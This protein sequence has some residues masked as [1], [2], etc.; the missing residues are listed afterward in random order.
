MKILVIGDF[1]GTFPAKLKKQI[2]KEKVDFIVG[3]GDYAGVE[4]WT[5]YILYIFNLK[6]L[7]DRESAEKFYGKKKY[8][9]LMKK[10]FKQGEKVLKELNSLGKGFY[11]FGNGDD[12]WYNYPFDRRI[13]QAK[14][15]RVRFLKK[16]KNIKEMT[17]KVKNYNK[18][19]FLGFGGYMDASANYNTR[20]GKKTKDSI[21]RYDHVMKRLRKAK[22]KLESLLKKTKYKEKIFVF[23]YPPKGFFDIIKQK[24]NPYSGGSVGVDFFAKAIRKHQPLIAFCGHMHEYQGKK[25][26]GNTWIINPGAASEGKA[27]IVEIN[28]KKKVKVKFIK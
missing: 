1:H 25:K 17:Y 15:S 10:D 21:K 22:K 24:G 14:K 4:E 5:K 27:A 8:K 16:I 7:E 12:G 3:V 26:L 9:E 6:K 23:H 28:D 11:I 18:I 2:S 20:K 19:S 13:L